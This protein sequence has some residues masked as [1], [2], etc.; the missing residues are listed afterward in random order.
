M[1]IRRTWVLSRG[2]LTCDCGAAIPA[3]RWALLSYA[4][5]RR[6]VRCVQCA[7][8]IGLTPPVEAEPHRRAS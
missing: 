2:A 3:Q 6:T 1:T 7:G 4:G 5:W 8:E